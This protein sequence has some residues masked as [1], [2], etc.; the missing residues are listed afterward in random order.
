MGPR[1]R[2][3]ILL[4]SMGGEAVALEI[5][6]WLALPGRSFTLQLTIAENGLF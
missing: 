2:R 6:V 5:A 3:H 4:A 1:R